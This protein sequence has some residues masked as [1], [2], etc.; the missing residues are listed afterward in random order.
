MCD[1][2]KEIY[3]EKDINN[4]VFHRGKYVRK[5]FIEPDSFIIIN[6]DRSF[7][8]IVNPGDPY[9]LGIIPNIKYC[10]YCGRDLIESEK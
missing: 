1:L 10:P 3:P 8:I 4:I 5:D 9:E 7:D 2:C 6:D